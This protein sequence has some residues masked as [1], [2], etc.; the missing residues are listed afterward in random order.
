MSA[1]DPARSASIQAAQT[2]RSALQAGRWADAA[3][4]YQKLLTAHPGQPEATH[5]WG[6]AM[7]QLGQPAMGIAM[8]QRALA[9]E[10][11]NPHFLFTLSQ[12]LQRSDRSQSFDLLARAAE[13]APRDVATV[14][15]HAEALRERGR[16]RDALAAVSRLCDGAGATNQ[17]ARR[18]RVELLFEL[19]ELAH[20]EREQ[21]SLL[22]LWPALAPEYRMGHALPAGT[23]P[24]EPPSLPG[25]LAAAAPHAAE[26]NLRVIDGLL[27]DFDSYR[28][29]ALAQRYHA[30]QYAEQNFPGVQTDGQAC[31]AL[32][33]RI[34]TLLGRTIKWSSPDNGAFRLSDAG[35]SARADIHVDQPAT[36]S[37]RHHAGVLYLNEPA[38]CRG[39]TSFWRHKATGWSRRPSADELRAQGFSSA[40]DFQRRALKATQK[41]PF[42]AL[43]AGRAGWEPLFEVPMR[44]N[45]L[46]VYRSDF[47]HSISD[48]FGSTPQDG[49]LVQLFFFETVG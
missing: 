8:M 39:G 4:L 45:R 2:A 36:E 17:A 40:L 48:V 47:F 21:G 35:S 7:C 27:D 22:A 34:A 5:G 29:Q 41:L 10:P 18:L 26:M 20:A 11:A 9:A 43:K 13:L 16:V 23:T 37:L 1:K 25:D 49:R 33:Q 14:L 30:V 3:N 28:A 24:A 19:D 31:D 32:M 46:V 44:A 6:M 12:A 38:Q 42:E 15:A